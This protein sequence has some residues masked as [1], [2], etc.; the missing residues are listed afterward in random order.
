M[1]AGACPIA[2]RMTGRL[3]DE[4]DGTRRGRARRCSCFVSFSF[5]TGTETA[6]VG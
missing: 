1:A 3:G 6:V 5:P 2:V 4:M